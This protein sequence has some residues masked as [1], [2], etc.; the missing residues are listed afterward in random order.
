MQNWIELFPPKTKDMLCRPLIIRAR[1]A[2]SDPGFFTDDL[3]VDVCDRLGLLHMK[4]EPPL[5]RIEMHRVMARTMFYDSLIR[6]HLQDRPDLIVVN[7]GSSLNT[8]F[9]RVDNGRLRWY[10]VDWPD[11]THIRKTFFPS[12]E[13]VTMIGQPVFDEAWP[14]M[15]K[16]EE[17]EQLIF[18]ADNLLSYL[19][20][21]EIRQ[22][23]DLIA[24]N[25]PGALLYCDVVLRSS[26][27][28]K[29]PE[30]YV[31]YLNK[32]TD[33]KYIEYRVKVEQTW[34]AGAL[35]P[36]KQSSGTRLLNRLPLYRDLNQIM[37]LRFNKQ[38]KW[39]DT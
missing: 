8:R 1:M 35:Y 26:K 32:V 28:L 2:E 3:A 37:Q 36:E 9:S 39:T 22:L 19:Q 33:I 24:S 17:P 27:R 16:Y 23:F 12:H 15:I 11:V 30:P 18:L 21:K 4:V 5:A 14:L 20:E 10:D 7:L 34:S 25:F 38:Q 31:F 29:L 6:K 13:R